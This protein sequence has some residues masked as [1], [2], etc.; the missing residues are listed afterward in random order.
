MLQI[1]RAVLR[2]PNDTTEMWLI[3]ANQT[4]QDILLRQELEGIP[5]DRFHL[6]YVYLRTLSIPYDIED[7]V[8]IR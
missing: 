7:G 3:F 2:D 4:E 1:I 5:N 8:G 6:W